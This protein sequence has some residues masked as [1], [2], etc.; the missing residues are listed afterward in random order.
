MANIDNNTVQLKVSET[1]PYFEGNATSSFS[2]GELC[3]LNFIV[4]PFQYE[5]HN[6]DGG[7]AEK[8]FAVENIYSGR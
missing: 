6:D 3:Q 2:P 1:S 4:T 5:H 8:L 7:A